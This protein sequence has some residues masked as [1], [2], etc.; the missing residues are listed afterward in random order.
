MSAYAWYPTR[1]FTERSNI[2]A[3]C[4]RHGVDGGYRTLQARSAADPEW[5]WE[6]AVQDI[7]IVWHQPPLRVCDDSGGIAF[8][9]WF[10]GAYTNLV[11]S[12]LER[13]VRQGSGQAPALRWE[14]ED[15]TR[16]VLTYGEAAAYSARVAGGLRELGVVSGDRVAGYL[17]P[18]PE[19][20][21]LLF[22]CARIGAVLVPLFSGFGAEAIAV[23]LVDAGVRVLVTAACAVRRGRRQ[24]ME[25]VARTS[26]ESATCVRH[27]V[28]VR[29]PSAPRHSSDSPCPP[30]FPAGPGVPSG[31]GGPDG[32]ARA[33]EPPSA[34]GGP[35]GRTVPSGTG[36]HERVGLAATDWHRLAASEPV[37]V[38]SVPV[39]APFLLLHTSGT[40]G[41]PKGAVHTHGGF[42]A[43]VGSET[44][45][46]LDLRPDD[47]VF[48][49]TD[50]GW[51]MFPLIAVGGTLAGACVLAYEGA[52]DHPDVT[53]LWRL[54]DDHE[55]TVF[56]SSPSLSRM[57]M[58]CEP[59]DPVVPSRLRVLGST[60][61]P[62]TEDAWRWYFAEFGGKRCP[63][64]NI[65][66]GTEVGGSL[67]ASAPTLPQ[68][69][70][71][72]AGPCLG[73]AAV[74]ED[75]SGAQPPEGQLGELVVKRSWPGMTR[76]LWRARER[77]AQTYF[78]RRPGR[79]SHGDLVSRTG[80]EWFV[81][82]RLDDVIKLAGKRLGPTEVEDAVVGDP[83]V[84][85]AA[86]VGIPH[87]VK[88]E[89]LW[90]FAV[91]ADGRSLG[92][93]EAERIRGRVAGSLGAAFRP[94]RVVAVP[95]LP[96]TRNGKVMRRLVRDLV[97]GEAPGDLSTLVNPACLDAIR[98]ALHEQ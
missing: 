32:R 63:V 60:G 45:Y 92:E 47:V 27:L 76:G 69:P 13:R 61:E 83:A 9:R 29:E 35:K 21:V 89:A 71:G 10:P 86:A 46:N 59:R 4:R 15:G 50:P 24:D 5:F 8:T 28:V 31:N 62:W 58:G 53:R 42:P 96:R 73:I 26:L 17:P 54:L 1:E 33:A 95:E 19:A 41:R 22:A 18:G 51:I 85:E 81:H 77:F 98:A 23:R 16:G 88:G 74:V 38:V 87:P 70:C 43:Q 25:A 14:R 64:I 66:G 79:W 39:T 40:T 78:V 67:L 2:T 68:S 30:A 72:F 49:V 3:F 90:C 11:D 6:R 34:G 36:G 12:C 91:P 48:W 20:F 80:D 7:G 97:T 37:P 57:L 94:A 65:C 52:I 75:D 44:R 84:A 56:G 82:G 55:V 93:T